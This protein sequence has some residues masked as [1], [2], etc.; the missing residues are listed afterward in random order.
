[1]TAAANGVQGIAEIQEQAFDLVITDLVMPG[2]DGFK[3][4]DD[5]RV[6]SPETV[7]V[8]I[9]GTFRLSRLSSFA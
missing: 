7:V 8:A 4:M 3:V 5:L 1:V 9:T 2:T 6:H